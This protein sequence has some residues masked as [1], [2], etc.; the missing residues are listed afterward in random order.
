MIEILKNLNAEGPYTTIDSLKEQSGVYVIL[1]RNFNYQ[2]WTVL[3][4]GESATV[5]S[6]VTYHD[7]QNQ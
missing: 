6:R 1:G 4:V 5:K 2:N 7:R 3:D